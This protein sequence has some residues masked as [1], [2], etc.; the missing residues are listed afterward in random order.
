[1]IISYYISIETNKKA[2]P[3]T[4]NKIQL[5]KGCKIYGGVKMENKKIC[6]EVY[7]DNKLIERKFVDSVDFK[8]TKEVYKEVFAPQ[9][10]TIKEIQ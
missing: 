9:G 4:A 2:V 6:F 7:K 5:L 1:M 10:Y 3:T 8:I